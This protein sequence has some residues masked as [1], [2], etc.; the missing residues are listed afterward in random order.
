MMNMA[1]KGNSEEHFCKNLLFRKLVKEMNAWER[2]AVFL[3]GLY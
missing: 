3:V 2:L 1:P